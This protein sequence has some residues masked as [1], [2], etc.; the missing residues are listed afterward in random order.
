MILPYSF[1]LHIGAV[2]SGILKWFEREGRTFSWRSV[3]RAVRRPAGEPVSDP[4][5]ILISEVMLQQTQTARVAEKLPEFLEKFPTVQALAAASRGELIRAW[6]GMGYNRRALRLQETA[7]A[8]VERYGGVFPRDPAE[9]ASLP[10][11]GPYTASA[12][13]CFAFGDEVPVVDV[14]I[15]R[16]LSRIFFKCHT[17]EQLMPRATVDRLAGAIAPRG[18]YYRW[19][20]ALMDLGA[21][22]CTAR[23]P[24]C[25]RCPIA[26]ICLS[27]YPAQ[28]ELFGAKHAA[29]EEPEIRGE[30]RRI[31]RGRVVELLRREHG[32]MRVGE[33][34]DRLFT[35]GL[36]DA[37]D[38]HDRR[39]L[40]GA[41]EG[42]LEDGLI[43]RGGAVREGRLEEH[44]LVRLPE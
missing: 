9:L 38:L 4:Y 39:K 30:P 8:I 2:Q 19:H 23:R 7:I 33:I 25:E 44:D 29:K 18:D 34:I 21:T 17:P 20:Q 5:M 42:L 6:Q 31:W 43:E 28:M 12:V 10:G 27:A 16:V 35:P 3:E 32:L 26:D 22:I 1:T 24:A 37:S 13:A 15:I 41:V 11:L 40:L 36:F 14:N